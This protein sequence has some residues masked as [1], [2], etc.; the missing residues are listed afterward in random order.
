MIKI[1]HSVF[2]LPFALA[3]AFLA[4]GGLPEWRIL[5]LVVIAMI[6]AR[7]AAMAFNRFLDSEIDGQNPRTAMRS[8]PAG[9]LS[10]SFALGF[11][12]VCLALFV[13]ICAR[14]N[15][16]AL[17]CSPLVILVLLGYSATK[18]FTRYSHFVLGLA[19]GLAP[20]G[21]WV[22][23]T[24]QLHW[25]PVLLG[26]AVAGWT[27]GFDMIYACQDIEF[28]R[29]VG[30]HSI[31]AR[32]GVKKTLLLSRSLHLAMICLLVY[33][34]LHWS[35]HP[36]YW[37]G[38]TI[39]GLCIIYEHYLVWDGDLSKVDMAFFTMNGA[40]SLIFG[41]ATMTAAVLA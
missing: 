22:A 28:D 19:L 8:I 29:E 35:F 24:G 11:T 33:L 26:L 3:S 21:A 36:V 17:V 23:V 39:V 4:A 16:L 9:R 34:G 27:A 20:V 2:A 40:I 13:F 31:P 1:E 10:R 7:S 12:L 38:M 25:D 30:L 41:A 6:A 15:P 14:L 37:V 5:G 18:R 32:I